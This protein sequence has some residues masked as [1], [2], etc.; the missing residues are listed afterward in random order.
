VSRYAFLLV[1]VWSARAYAFP[2]YQISR[3]DTCTSCHLSPAGGGLLNE[4]GLNVAETFSQWGTPSAFL[5]GAVPTPS[6]LELSGDLR[7]AAGYEKLRPTGAFITFPM[8]AEVY[9][10]A[11]SGAFSLHVTAGARVPEYPDTYGPSLFASREHWLQWEQKPGEN[12]GLYIRVGR[13]MPVYGLRFAEHPMYTRQYGG[14]PLYGEAYALAAEYIEPGWEVHATAFVHDPLQGTVEL[15]NGAAVYAEAR[16]DTATSVGVESKLDLT[17]DDRKLYGGVTAKHHFK[18]PDI[19]V[20][21]EAELVHQKISAGGTANGV[22]ASVVGTYFVGAF[23]VDLGIG[24]YDP[25]LSIRYLD[26]EAADLNVHW[27]A[28]SHIELLFTSRLQM[29]EL[30]AGGLSS[31]YSLLQFHYRI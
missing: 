2:Q 20:S 4:N 9:G 3:E 27:V 21:G 15:G 25:H 23:L 13:F 10:A 8:Q 1:L 11:T 22:V 30:G 26:Q 16:L 6:W 14:T 5:N 19:L 31:G 7:W 28:T 12:H 17:T 24:L 18:G 29:L